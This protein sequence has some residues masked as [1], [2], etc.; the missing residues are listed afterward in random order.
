MLSL[1]FLVHD[2]GKKTIDWSCRDLIPNCTTEGQVLVD[3]LLTS[4]QGKRQKEVH[5]AAFRL[6]KC[7]DF[8]RI[9]DKL[10]GE[11]SQSP[12]YDVIRLTEMG[13]AEFEELAFLPHIKES[14]DLVIDRILA[15]KFHDT[16]KEV[17]ASLV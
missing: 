2:D 14:K 6:S 7:I 13:K 17:F 12:S 8:D 3:D 4:L 16:I 11:C 10:S 15:S 9:F 1:L 5:E